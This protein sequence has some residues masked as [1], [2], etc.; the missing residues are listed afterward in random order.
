MVKKKSK[1]QEI[2]IPSESSKKSSSRCGN[3][4]LWMISTVVLTILLV[5]FVSYSSFSGISSKTAEQKFLE[6]TQSQGA[7]VE[8]LGV[9]SVGDLYEIK[10]DF[11][12]QEGEFHVSK[13]GKYIGQMMD[14]EKLTTITGQ[15]V[16]DT[17]TQTQQP[18]A[19]ST[20]DQA[21]LLEFNTCLAEKG[22]KIYGANW[23]GY[24]VRWVE[25]LGG[26]ST[27]SPVYIEC[28]ENDA[29]CREEGVTGYPTT[30]INGQAYNGARTVEAIA[31]ATGCTAPSLTGSVAQTTTQAS[32]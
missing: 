23:C 27:V 28:T 15:A 31:Q 17:P 6:F 29:L 4:N 26:Y 10:F 3:V 12:G 13:D 8:V 25:A 14:L 9:K 24:T 20:E 22:V 21:K 2:S 19:Y 5:G 7:D 16:T 18:S 32:C 1:D 30:K 11:Q